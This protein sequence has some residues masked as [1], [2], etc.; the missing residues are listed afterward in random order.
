M[1]FIWFIFIHQKLSC[2][3]LGVL[4]KIISHGL[5]TSTAFLFLLD[6]IDTDSRR[7]WAPFASPRS[8]KVSLRF[9]LLRFLAF[10]LRPLAHSK[11]LR[12]HWP[13][14]S[15]LDSNF[16]FGLRFSLHSLLAE[17]IS[18]ATENK[19]QTNLNTET[20]LFLR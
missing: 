1:R 9:V 14:N 8:I 7:E 4:S 19:H 15:F 12:F 17:L 5:F 13:L 6:R 20:S 10:L 18:S 3:P 16:Q 2:F 11:L